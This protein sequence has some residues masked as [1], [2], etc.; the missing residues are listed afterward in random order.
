MIDRW[1]ELQSF[2][3]GKQIMVTGHTGFKGSWLCLVLTMLGA[4]VI[5]YALTPEDV[6]LFN[7][8]KIDEEIT[9]I[10]GDIRDFTAIDKCIT[11][12]KPEIVFHMAAQPLVRESY[13]APRE[14]FETNVMGTVNLLE[15]LRKTESIR[16]IINVTTDKVY[17][18]REWLWG[19]R[20]NEELCGNDP[21]S[22]SKSCSELVTYSYQESFFK[23][24]SEIAISTVRSGNVIGGGDYNIDRIIPDCYR[25]AC[26]SS[27]ICIRNPLSIRPYQHVIESIYAYLVI[28]QKQY[29]SKAIE[30]A[31]NV[32]PNES[33][34]VTT[35]MLADYF[36]KYWGE[37]LS[38]IDISV[39]NELH[40][41]NFLKLDNA[42]VKSNF[43]I[44]PHWNID[45]AVK[46]TVDFYKCINTGNFN[47][48][49]Q[50]A[51][52]QIKLYFSGIADI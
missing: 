29:G 20:E 23:N 34:C 19:Y 32:G 24:R 48:L 13:R 2:Y 5:G 1:S 41:A 15:S 51:Q 49:K 30:G 28:A 26:N 42:K 16:S 12:F 4:E 39:A 6:S 22:N 11:H 3:N 35:A 46:H 43:G 31:Y 36:V 52:N 21:Y 47:V 37:S 38:W 9:S 27:K 40:E 33:D 17:K 18:N 25:A 8:L 14:T 7:Q 50:N 44:T 10:V 45:T